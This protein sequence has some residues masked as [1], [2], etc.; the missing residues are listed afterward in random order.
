MTAAKQEKK[1]LKNSTKTRTKV[2]ATVKIKIHSYLFDSTAV[3]PCWAEE[4]AAPVPVLLL[5]RGE[6]HQ[7][8]S[9]HRW[10]PPPLSGS[11]SQSPPSSPLPPPCPLDCPTPPP[12]SVVLQ[13]G[14]DR[15]VPGH[16]FDRRGAPAGVQDRLLGPTGL[17]GSQ[18]HLARIETSLV[19]V[20]V[21]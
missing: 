17:K 9:E 1:K 16:C 13:F 8:C 5:P 2:F 12:R 18:R 19:W 21:L 6:G 10:I 4:E 20:L 14:H 7:T 3:L 15:W 11:V